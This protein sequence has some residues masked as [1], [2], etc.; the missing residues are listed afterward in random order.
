MLTFVAMLCVGLVSC[1]KDKDDNNTTTTTN[2]GDNPG[3]GEDDDDDDCVDLGLPSG[4]IWARYNIGATKPEEYGDYFSWGETQPKNYPEWT[5]ETYR[6]AEGGE[7][8]LTKYC[9]GSSYGHNGF[10]DNLTTLLPED[11]AAVVNWGGGWRTPTIEDFREL[12]D[13]TTR[14]WTSINGV[15][16]MLFTASNGKSIFFPAAGDWWG[17]ELIYEGENGLYWSS[18]LVMGN[19][20]QVYGLYTGSDGA[21]TCYLGRF[22]G[23]P[24]RA[25]RSAK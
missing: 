9:S 19:S 4:L 21:T 18:T 2:G 25:V 11:D 24:V 15:D 8:E 23:M 13:H 17:S 7:R 14:V 1:S 16:G 10:T 22:P 20:T 12:I 5:W 6:Y 3:G